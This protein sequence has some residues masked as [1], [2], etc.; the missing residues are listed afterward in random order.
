MLRPRTIL[1][2]DLIGFSAPLKEVGEK[3]RII[4]IAERFAAKIKPQSRITKRV[5]T[6]FARVHRK[7]VN[8]S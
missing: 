5:K 3:W 7:T 4:D 6:K 2:P 8:L 1:T